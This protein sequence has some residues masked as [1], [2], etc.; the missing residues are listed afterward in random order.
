MTLEERFEAFMK[1]YEDMGI[2]NEEMKNKISTW[3]VNLA[4]Q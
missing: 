3:G 4:K 2:Y 1:N